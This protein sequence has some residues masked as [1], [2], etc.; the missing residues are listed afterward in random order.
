MVAWRFALQPWLHFVAQLFVN[1]YCKLLLAYS[2][3]L[4]LLFNIDH[5]FVPQRWCGL[6]VLSCY[7]LGVKV[8][9]AGHL[10]CVSLYVE[11]SIIV[12]YSHVILSSGNI[13]DRD[14]E[15]SGIHD[16]LLVGSESSSCTV[17]F[18]HVLQE[19]IIFQVMRDLLSL[20]H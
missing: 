5:E 7:L 14:A 6:I 20:A 17:G 4:N 3:I 8:R 2:W 11:R 12:N 13:V 16:L 10:E 15:T 1:V 19:E 18:W 9:V